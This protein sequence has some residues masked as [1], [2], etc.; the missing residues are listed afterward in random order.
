[1]LLLLLEQ[2]LLVQRCDQSQCLGG[3]LRS[4]VIGAFEKRR[5]VD[6]LLFR[7]IYGALILHARIS[8]L[9]AVIVDQGQ[10][11]V[12]VVVVSHVRHGGRMTNLAVIRVAVLMHRH[13]DSV[14]VPR[15]F[16]RED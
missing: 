10:M 12:V 15:G 5:L 3:S 4:R 7:L 8:P 16:L 14:L 13:V 2:E 6:D 9:R 11:V 1:M